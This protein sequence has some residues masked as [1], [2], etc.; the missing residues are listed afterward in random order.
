MSSIRMEQTVGSGS[1]RHATIGTTDI[2][3]G[4]TTV[5]I[6]EPDG[7]MHRYAYDEPDQIDQ[8]AT[9]Y[10]TGAPQQTLIERILSLAFDRL[11]LR[12]VELRVCE[13]GEP[14]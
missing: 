3:V 13:D 1:S 12:S 5:I 7:S 10:V 4:R 8:H 2:S 9:I 11:K 14:L 6:L